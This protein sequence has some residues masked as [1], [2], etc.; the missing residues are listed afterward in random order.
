MDKNGV[1]LIFIQDCVAG[2]NF[3]DDKEAGHFKKT[4]EDKLLAK[5]QRKIGRLSRRVARTLT[6]IKMKSFRTIVNG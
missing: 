5:Q 4:I 2:M 3:A 1:L 6:N